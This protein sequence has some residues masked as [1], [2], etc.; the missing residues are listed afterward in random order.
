MDGSKIMPGGGNYLLLPFSLQVRSRIT[1]QKSSIVSQCTCFV[2]FIRGR[3]SPA[4]KGS[5]KQHPLP[6]SSTAIELSPLFAPAA[7]VLKSSHS[8]SSSRSVQSQRKKSNRSKKRVFTKKQKAR[9]SVHQPH[10]RPLHPISFHPLSF[11]FLSCCLFLFPQ[12]R[13]HARKKSVENEIYGR[14]NV[15]HAEG[16]I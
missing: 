5:D 15:D 8:S 6:P 3:V 11:H 13:E 14:G 12:T 7:H 10:S 16:G 2:H 9:V 1:L 4:S